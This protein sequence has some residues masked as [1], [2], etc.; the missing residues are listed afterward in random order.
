[1]RSSVFGIASITVLIHR[2]CSLHSA[3]KVTAVNLTSCAR[4]SLE[5]AS[6]PNIDPNADRSRKHRTVF[7]RCFPYLWVSFYPIPVCADMN[8][9]IFLAAS[10]CMSLVQCPFLW[11]L[12][13]F[14]LKDFSV[15]LYSYF[16][17]C[18]KLGF[19]GLPRLPQLLV[20]NLFLFPPRYT[21]SAKMYLN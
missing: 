15:M 5:N 16:F 8:P 10:A 9:P 19:R 1:M 7:A 17:I 6:D 2:C 14:I 20:Y 11:C 18:Q 3:Q 13:S 21:P 4:K 12:S